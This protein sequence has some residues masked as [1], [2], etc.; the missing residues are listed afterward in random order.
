LPRTG[1]ERLKKGLTA[2]VG[3]VAPKTI[4]ESGDGIPFSKIR[5]G[6]SNT[7]AFL[8][9]NEDHA[10]IWTQPD[11]LKVDWKE[12]LKGLKLWKVEKGA[13]FLAVFCDGTVQAIGDQISRDDLRRLLQKNDGEPIGAIP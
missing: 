9:A 2:F 13:V 3:P 5:D 10:V 12:P 4:F 6:T 7:L 1:D 8:E 11:D